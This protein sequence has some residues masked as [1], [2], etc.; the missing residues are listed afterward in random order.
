MHSAW[1]SPEGQVCTAL[2]SYQQLAVK[3]VDISKTSICVSLKPCC[4]PRWE[5]RA[6]RSF[7]H[8]Q[9]KS[10]MKWLLH[11]V[12]QRSNCL[13][14]WMCSSCDPNSP[15]ASYLQS[16]SR[17]LQ[18]PYPRSLPCSRCAWSITYLLKWLIHCGC[19]PWA[20]TGSHKICSRLKLGTARHSTA[21]HS[22]A[23]HGTAQPAQPARHGTAQL[24]TAQHST[25]Q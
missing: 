19:T 15:G 25:A 9:L 17:W 7:S 13:H 20:Q 4:A 14:D 6:A 5:S 16:S 3:Q 22:T 21:L 2:S 1:V 8:F 24:S 11:D 18:L 12:C 10:V 23:W